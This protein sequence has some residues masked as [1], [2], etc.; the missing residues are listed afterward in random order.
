MASSTVS[1]LLILGL[2]GLGGAF[3]IQHFTSGSLSLYNA[4]TV[5]PNLVAVIE[6][7]IDGNWARSPIVLKWADQAQT[8]ELRDAI[9][10]ALWEQLWRMKHIDNAADILNLY[11]ELTWRADVP[12]EDQAKKWE[13]HDN[14]L[15][16][17]WNT[18][19]RNDTIKLSNLYSQFSRRKD[20]PSSWFLLINQTIID[21]CVLLFEAQ[22]YSAKPKE[23]FSWINLYCLAVTS[24]Q[25][26]EDILQVLF[27]T[28][29]VM[30]TPSSVA[31]R[32]ENFNSSLTLQTQANLKLFERVVETG[33][34][35][36]PALQALQNNLR[37]LLE[38]PR[39]DK[40][41]DGSL[42]AQV[43]ARLSKEEQLLYTARKICI[44]NV[45]AGSLYMH[46]CPRTLLMCNN[47]QR[48]V[49]APF[50][51]QRLLTNDSR[52]QFAFYSDYWKRYLVLNKNVQTPTN[53]S[54]TKDVYSQ[55][56]FSW[57]RVVY[58][59]GGISLFDSETEN[60]VVC[61]G[62]PSQTVGGEVQVY[63]RKAAEFQTHQRECTW[64]LED[65]S[66]V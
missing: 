42:R 8:Q 27:D 43:Y 24:P 57:W 32:L 3:D 41:V 12:L 31:K 54:I 9:Y 37:S 18:T 20:V 6:S 15:S 45:T 7:E 66:F 39:F 23:T 60:S 5:P 10:T 1:V 29:L 61:A 33:K 13:L 2:L 53:A 40:D 55:T 34:A 46:E 58:G 44:R 14:I 59:N 56:Y 52:P 62:D 64:S 51:V 48:S 36:I 11:D 47:Y 16:A 19:Q 28:V 21:R 25:P 35:D 38:N 63:T 30:E 26:L 65:C 49:R 17:L 4:T 22:L 50:S